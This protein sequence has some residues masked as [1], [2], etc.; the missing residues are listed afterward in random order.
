MA[1]ARRARD[2]DDGRPTALG[3]G[4][5]RHATPEPAWGYDVDSRVAAGE[6]T[7]D[8]PLS[9]L[10]ADERD[11]TPF[12]EVPSGWWPLPAAPHRGGR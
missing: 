8:D 6:L 2:D 4:V 11:P 5:L 1:G 10:L 3:D 12:L 9:E 7:S